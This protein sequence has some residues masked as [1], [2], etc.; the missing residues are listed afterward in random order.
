HPPSPPTL[1]SPL[2][3]YTTLFRS[4]AS[5]ALQS[6]GQR[7]VLCRRPAPGGTSARPVLS[8]KHGIH[9]NLGKFY[10][11]LYL[12]PA[13]FC[14]IIKSTKPDR[15]ST[16]LNSSHVSISYAVFC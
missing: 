10:E 8:R 1:S 4:T 16:R 2:F 12:L 5:L 15:K 11:K 3:P 7:D 9:K 6:G 13:P 14:A